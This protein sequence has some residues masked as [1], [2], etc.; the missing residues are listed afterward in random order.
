VIKIE[1]NTL[2]IRFSSDKIACAAF[3]ILF[4][5]YVLQRLFWLQSD[6]PAYRG[7]IAD[8][9]GVCI[10]STALLVATFSTHLD[11]FAGL[12]ATI[13]GASLGALYFIATLGTALADPTYIDWL[14]RGDWAQHFI[15]WQFF[16]KSIWKWPL[17]AFDEFW[18]PIGTSVVYTDSLP[19]VAI[20]L[21]LVGADLPDRFQYIGFSFLANFV[22]QGV[23]GAL[24]M[25]C[26]M[27]RISVQA[28]GAAFMVV[29][30]VL[31]ARVEQDT[32]TAQWLLL[33]ALW[34]Y[35]RD[36]DVRRAYMPWTVLTGVGALVHPYLC[37]MV[38][39][40][41][42]AYYA[43]SY[44][45]RS[46]KPVALV[47]HLVLIFSI[48]WLLW[49]AS[50]V[51][52]LKVRSGFDVSQ[53]GANLL[54]WFNAASFSRWIAPLPIAGDSYEGVGYLG[55]GVLV[56][57]AISLAVV[58]SKWRQGTQTRYAVAP[59]VVAVALMTI[60]AFSTRLTFGSMVLVDFTPKHLPILGAFRATGRFIWPS[61]Y[62]ITLFSVVGVGAAN[63]R[64][65]YAVLVVAFAIQLLDLTPLQ[66]S[67]ARMRDGIFTAKSEQVL[68]DDAWRELLRAKERIVLLPPAGCDSREAAPYF[69]F[70]LLAA[71]H[72]LTINTGYLARFDGVRREKY[73]E[74]LADEID[75]GERDAKTLYIVGDELVEHFKKTSE[76]AVTCDVIDG[77]SACAV[78]AGTN[79]K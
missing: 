20:P 17:G 70:S 65:S 41:A 57:L 3:A 68:D 31:L 66:M 73:C 63:G 1:R 64:L 19:L 43:R 8:V 42:L 32:L 25:R 28:V 37:A 24:L 69:P 29:T 56:L 33:A 50:G 13:V 35:F 14:F 51:F 16:R 78:A 9:I 30:P 60:F 7:H 49:W 34:M 5:L 79:S 52:V 58:L 59:L 36:A 39:M 10:A 23:F 26:F 67:R 44:I 45:A 77:Y 15:G 40:L 18:Y 27:S 2:G 53:Y 47:S 38:L 55:L 74:Q 6:D 72:R 71:D 75:R 46:L 54:A 21:K 61:V 62:A 48:V 76:R 12:R 22:L 4:A 11:R